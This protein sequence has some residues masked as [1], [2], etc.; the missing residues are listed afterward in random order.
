MDCEATSNK[1]LS[2]AD[3]QTDKLVGYPQIHGKPTRARFNWLLKATNAPTEYD[4]PEHF[5][6]YWSEEEKRMESAHDNS[7]TRS[8]VIAACYT[9]FL[10][11]RPPD[12]VPVVLHPTYDVYTNRWKQRQAVNPNKKTHDTQLHQKKWKQ[13][14]NLLKK[15]GPDAIIIKQESEQEC[16]DATVLRIC[17]AFEAGAAA[18]AAAA[19]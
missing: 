15:K 17:Q 13:Q 16:V 7:T 10:L 14:K 8:T 6:A 4:A 1:E 9:E 19:E 2:R 11:G 12:V 18:A 5:Q 3:R